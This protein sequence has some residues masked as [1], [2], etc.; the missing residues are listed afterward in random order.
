MITRN[1][2]IAGAGQ[3]ESRG[4]VKNCHHDYGNGPKYP[5]RAHPHGLRDVKPG[6]QAAPSVPPGRTNA[7][8]YGW[9]FN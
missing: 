8:L 9:R 5:A 4:Q 2:A 1:A 3:A 6:Y 7:A